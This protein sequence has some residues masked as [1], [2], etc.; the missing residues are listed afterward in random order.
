MFR[1]H[2]AETM[3]GHGTT[4]IFSSVIH[5]LA[6]S[7]ALMGKICPLNLDQCRPRRHRIYLVIDHTRECCQPAVYRIADSLIISTISVLKSIGP[8]PSP[9]MS[10][11]E[12]WYQPNEAHGVTVRTI[13]YKALW[14]HHLHKYTCKGYYSRIVYIFHLGHRLVF[15]A[16]MGH[17]Y[18]AGTSR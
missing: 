16:S 5:P 12:L 1:Y 3:I 7:R 6:L 13:S 8:R 11:T 10:A 17:N 2:K 9:E 4:W 18:G 15:V 14:W